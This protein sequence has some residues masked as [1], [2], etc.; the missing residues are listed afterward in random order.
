MG[1][2]FPSLVGTLENHIIFDLLIEL[3]EWYEGPRAPQHGV[4]YTD[5]LGSGIDLLLLGGRLLG[6]A[7]IFDTSKQNSLTSRMIVSIYF[8][9]QHYVL[10]YTII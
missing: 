2:F 3:P 10:L 8:Q 4:V 5:F 6:R 7:G 1:S 9:G